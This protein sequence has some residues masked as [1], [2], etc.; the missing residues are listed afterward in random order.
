MADQVTQ[1]VI[2][3]LADTQGKTGTTSYR[4]ATDGATNPAT[5]AAAYYAVLTPLTSCAIVGAVG[6]TANNVPVGSADTNAYNVRDKL[7]VE[8][9]GS[10]NDHHVCHI[11]DPNPAVFMSTNFKDVDPTNSLWLDV[12]SAIETN[13]KDKLGNSVTVIRGYRQ[14]SRNLKGSLRF[15]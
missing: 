15:A 3:R 1:K 10:Q 7:A 8:Y 2:L 13:V 12:V 9:V 14:M 11:P 4:I 6:Q 5:T